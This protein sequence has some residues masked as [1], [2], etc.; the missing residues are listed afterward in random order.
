MISI[1]PFTG[2]RDAISDIVILDSS[3]YKTASLIYK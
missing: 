2:L 3:L 1:A